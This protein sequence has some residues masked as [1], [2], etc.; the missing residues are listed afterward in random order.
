MASLPQDIICILFS[1]VYLKAYIQ[2][3]CW[4]QIHASVL[5]HFH[6][7][8]EK[9][10]SITCKGGRDNKKGRCQV[11]IYV[12]LTSICLTAF[13]FN[14][15]IDFSLCLQNHNKLKKNLHS[16]HSVFWNLLSQIVDSRSHVKNVSLFS[17]I[18][19]KGKKESINWYHFCCFSKSLAQALFKTLLN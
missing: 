19:A 17:Y 5:K 13:Y 1:R 9:I 18:N 8:K 10:G 11:S 3:N 15:R 12:S 4:Y 6:F 7:L 16:K 14:T 2:L